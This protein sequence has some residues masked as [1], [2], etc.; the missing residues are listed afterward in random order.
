MRTNFI[1]YESFDGGRNGR[2]IRTGT[3]DSSDL[4]LQASRPNLYVIQGTVNDRL[5]KIVNGAIT[6]RTQQ[7]IDSDR[8]PR[9]NPL[10]EPASITVRQWNDL[11]AR[12]TALEGSA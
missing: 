10:D 4:A 3:C 11:T 1:V 9:P 8:P 7:E 6:P 5:Y 2:I 12:V